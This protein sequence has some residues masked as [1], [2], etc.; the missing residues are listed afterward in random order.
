MESLAHKE[1][2][3]LLLQLATMLLSARVFAEIAQKFKQPAVVG[4]IIA[5][6]VLGPTILGMII[7]TSLPI[8]FKVIPPRILPL[9]E[10]CRWPLS[11]CYL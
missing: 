5:G 4:E 11:S 8:C 6:I 9:M 1:V 7:P 3:N 10:L 2:I